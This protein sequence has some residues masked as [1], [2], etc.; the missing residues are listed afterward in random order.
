MTRSQDASV[1]STAGARSMVPALLTRMSTGRP[2]TSRSASAAT[3]ARSA[4]STRWPSNVLPRPSTSVCTSLPTGS[5]D[6]LTPTMSAPADA[7]ALAIA[8]PSP[9]RAPV[10]TARRPLQVEARETGLRA[11]GVVMASDRPG[12][13]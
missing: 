3:A 4:K 2:S 12:S 8:R 13:R 11:G 10:T 7:R 5:S 1:W 9:R 6:A